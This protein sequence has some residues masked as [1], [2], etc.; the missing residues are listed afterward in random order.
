M[1]EFP[2]LEL[3]L[4]ALRSRVEGHP[5]HQVFLKDPFILRSVHPPLRSLEGKVLLGLRRLGKRLVCEFES[6]LY[7]V[8]HLMI[9]GRFRWSRAQGK[10]PAGCMIA[11]KFESG[12]LGLSEAGSK[13]RA[14]VHLLQGETELSA[15]DPGGL[16]LETLRL[17]GFA[18]RLRNHRHTLK[19]ILTDPKIFAGIGNAYSDEILLAARLSPLRLSTQLEDDEVRALYEACRSV[20]QHWKEKLIAEWGDDFPTRVTAFHPDMAAHGKYLQPCPQCQSPIQRIR[21]ADNE[22]NY[23]AR[24]QTQGRLLADRSLSKLLKEDWP[25]TLEELEDTFPPRPSGQRL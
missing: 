6:E 3:Y 15:H 13:R 16:E 7:L 19:R 25:R 5:C 17:D 12:W 1:P 24:C 2:D 14:R 8:I 22:T 21:Y 11:W 18:T 10:P 9:A 23:C 4:H 20:L